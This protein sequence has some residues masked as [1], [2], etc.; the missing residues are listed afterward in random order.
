MKRISWLLI[1]P[2]VL[3]ATMSAP[4]A[5]VEFD[6]YSLVPGQGGAGGTGSTSSTGGMGGT[7]GDT[8][9][10]TGSMGGGGTGGAPDCTIDDDCP[11]IECTTAVS[12]VAGACK[13]TPTPNGELANSQL[14]GDCL[15]RVCDAE[16]NVSETPGDMI[17]DAYDWGPENPCYAKACNGFNSSPP[18]DGVTCTTSWGNANG[19]CNALKCGE[20]VDD[21]GCGMMEICREGRCIASTCEGGVKDGTESAVDC[22]GA[23]CLPC[24]AGKDCIADTDCDWKCDTAAMPPKCIAPTCSDGI[25]NGDE[26]DVDCG[27][28]AVCGKE[29][30]PKKCAAPL[31]C[32]YPTDCE[33]GVCKAGVCQ[34][35]S[36]V[37]YTQ[38]GDETGIDCG[39]TCPPCSP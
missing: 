35:R 33:S 37:D 19:K 31:K 13:W 12:C 8:T 18:K 39:G 22:G 7:G 15:D 10:S 9:S 26:T 25:K 34:A 2:L 27:G 11:I 14:Y 23:D 32:L 1:V 29:N 5:C 30:P 28:A 20:C 16:G 4:V 24:T 17:K 3:A 21:A 36:C 6:T 38:N